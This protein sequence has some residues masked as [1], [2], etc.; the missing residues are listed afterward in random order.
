MSH[1]SNEGD[2]QIDESD[3]EPKFRRRTAR[4][5]STDDIRPNL[6]IVTIPHLV[7]VI[8]R[9]QQH[10]TEM[11]LHV[12]KHDVVPTHSSSH[13][14]SLRQIEPRTK[15]PRR[16]LRDLKPK[17]ARD[18]ISAIRSLFERVSCCGESNCPCAAARPCKHRA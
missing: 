18:R 7:A 16:Q 13:E 3:A 4:R 14:L 8:P 10:A 12:R 5:I 15:C 9:K 11:L 1:A 17:S 2:R 6:A